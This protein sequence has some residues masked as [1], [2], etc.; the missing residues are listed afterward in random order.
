[1]YEL[2]NALGYITENKP[3]VTDPERYE[4]V[5]MHN[6]DDV[7]GAL[8]D[9]VF[10]GQVMPDGRVRPPRASTVILQ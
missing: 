4:N 9:C 1:M 7:G 5:S 8:M 10:G 3:N 6:K 2:G